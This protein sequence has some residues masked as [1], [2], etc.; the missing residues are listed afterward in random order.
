MYKDIGG[1]VVIIFY[2]K[3]VR[4]MSYYEMISLVI[5]IAIFIINLLIYYIYKK[6]NQPKL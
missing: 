5:A 1:D 2:W 3:E 6:N 4:H